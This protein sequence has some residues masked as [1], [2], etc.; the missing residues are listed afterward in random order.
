MLAIVGAIFAA[1]QV[2]YSA[3]LIAAYDDNYNVVKVSRVSSFYGAML[4]IR[5]TN[6]GPVSVVCLCLSVSV[7]HKSVF[8]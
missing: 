5:G 8:Y 1:Y 4:C 3:A 2:Y 6:H 7:C